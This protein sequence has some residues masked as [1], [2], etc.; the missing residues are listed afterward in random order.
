MQLIE[1]STGE[2]EYVLEG[3]ENEQDHAFYQA[4]QPFQLKRQGA[5][6]LIYTKDSHEL[7]SYFK[8][9]DNTQLVCSKDGY[10]VA[11]LFGG[12]RFIVG[13]ANSQ[14]QPQTAQQFSRDRAFP[15]LPRPH[16]TNYFPFR[17]ESLEFLD[18][19]YRK[20]KNELYD[21]LAHL[22]ND[23]ADFT[24]GK[25]DEYL[26]GGAETDKRCR[27][28]VNNNPPKI[29]EIFN[30]HVFFLD[31]NKQ[32][33]GTISATIVNGTDIYLYD[34]IVDYFKCLT[35][36]DQNK[37]RALAETLRQL[38][39][40]K[41]KNQH[42][43]ELD[44]K[45]AAIKKE[46][47][48]IIEPKR[49]LLL[50]FLFSA[51][52]DRICQ[53]LQRYFAVSKEDTNEKVRAFIR[54]ASGR[55]ASYEALNCGKANDNIHVIHGK[56]TPYAEML[57]KHITQLIAPNKIQLTN[58]SSSQFTIPSS[59]ACKRDL[60]QI[61]DQVEIAVKWWVEQIQSGQGYQDNVK[62]TL[63]R[64]NLPEFKL[65]TPPIH[66]QQIQIFEESL[67]E[68]LTKKLKTEDS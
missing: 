37:V 41:Q 39:Q 48:E 3:N 15:L 13:Q 50:Q 2:L 45:I 42:H 32:V 8:P 49:S 24:P 33:I 53:S 16:E 4:I 66:K 17:C 65:E 40:E 26:S 22:F 11:A 62:N 35:K 67:A 68:Q 21:Q 14:D 30:D 57:A 18:S 5:T 38:E 28:N 31:A 23:C 29:K 60:S 6:V 27:F 58:T 10:E 7:V 25:Q 34:E 52:R 56:P 47:S 61:Q 12:K 55:E 64:A 51:A 54:V 19:F 36:E 44:S 1:Q 59:T 63:L 43:S 46:L 9:Y 20:N